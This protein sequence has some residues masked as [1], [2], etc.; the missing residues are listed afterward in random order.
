[1]GNNFHYE[2]ASFQELKPI[3]EEMLPGKAQRPIELFPTI[4]FCK[5][6][7]GDCLEL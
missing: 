3:T 5:C 2:I 6:V 1:M 7:Q 4:I